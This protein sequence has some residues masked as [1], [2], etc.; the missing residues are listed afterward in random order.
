MENARFSLSTTRGKGA[1]Q[2]S[3]Y[4]LRHSEEAGEENGVCL[5]VSSITRGYADAKVR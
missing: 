3:S 1:A 2:S 4:P 5:C